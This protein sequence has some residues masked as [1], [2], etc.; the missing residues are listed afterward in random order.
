[1]PSRSDITYFG[2]GPALLPTDV[3]EDAAK[4]LLNYNDTGLGV[5]EHSHRSQ[6]ATDIIN[7]AKADLASCL[8]IPDDYEILFMQG[9]GSGEFSATAYN[10]AGAWVARKH[11]AMVDAAGGDAAD[12]K[13][14]QQLKD[15]VDKHLKMDYLV[16]GG[17]SQKAAAEAA[18]LFGAEHVNIAADSRES[19][20]G[21]FG[22][23]PD[24]STWTLSE[25]AAMVYYCANETV[26]GVEFPEFPK[27]LAPGPDGKG[28][29]VVADMSSNILTKKIPVGNFSA[30]FFGA[31]KNLG[32]TGVTVVILKKSFLPPVTPQ[33]SAALMRQL[34]LPIPPIVFQYETIAKNNSLY[35][36]LSIFDVYVAGRVLKKLLQTYPDKVQGQQA[37]SEK[38]AQLIY[39]ALEA[40]PNIYKVI[41]NKAVRSRVNICFRVTKGDNVDA[42]E[43]AFLEQGVAQ[44]LTGLKGH[45]SLGGIRA[46]N[47]NS[48]PLEGAEKLAKF[49]T[50]F[51]TS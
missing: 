4:A 23:I 26:D 9:G 5:A 42:A 24:E 15:T 51:A 43:K 6:L 20:G 28:P 48:V 16:T 7:Q 47:Y 37:V 21:K 2:A 11:K 34:G 29:I 44:G 1:M 36:T 30:I 27:S 12:P 40:F 22:T 45:R 46:S 41:P 17:W 35:N 32:V 14:I 8:D 3:L 10:F 38:K 25:D 19:N 49:I 13:L 33:P 18:R 39:N 50:A 31:Q